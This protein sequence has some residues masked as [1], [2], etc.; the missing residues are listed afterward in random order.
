MNILDSF[1]LNGKVALVTG[2][3]HGIGFAMAEALSEAGAKVAFCCSRESSRDKAAANYKAKGVDALGFVCDV[4]NE[5]Q[6]K[7]MVAEIKEKL[8]AR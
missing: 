2:A 7:A 5:D 4:T 6:V 3:S 8:G 1:S